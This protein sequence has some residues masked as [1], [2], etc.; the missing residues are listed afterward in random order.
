VEGI[1]TR[2]LA[3]SVVLMFMPNE[4]NLLGLEGVCRAIRRE[5]TGGLK[6]SIRLH[7]V[8]ANV[9]HVDDED[10]ILHRQMRAFRKRLP[11]R[12]LSGLIRRYESMSLLNQSIFTLDRPHTRLAR[13]YR[14]LVR[15]LQGYNLEDRDGILTFLHSLPARLPRSVSR[16][17]D[18]KHHL[19]DIV[20]CFKDDGEIMQL[21]GDNSLA[22]RLTRSIEMPAE[23]NP[24]QTT[25]QDD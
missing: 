18:Y 23:T 19:G 16:M 14:G 25:D 1:C 15:M 6:K 4:Q 10:R 20:R 24:S 3:D 2:Q 21:I 9:P 12:D 13:S 17:L 7:F 5:E 8:A 11:F 22:A